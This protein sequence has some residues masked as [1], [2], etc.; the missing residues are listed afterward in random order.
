MANRNQNHQSGR[1]RDESR[2]NANRWRED[3]DE[4]R[5]SRAGDRDYRSDYRSYEA[6]DE[7]G[8]VRAD[9]DDQGQGRYGRDTGDQSGSTGRYAG[10]GDFGQGDYSG[11]RRGNTGQERYGQ[12]GYG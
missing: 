7:G 4:G 8:P 12:S 6:G 1:N 3:D 5:Y 2:D 10:Y 11:G 9:N